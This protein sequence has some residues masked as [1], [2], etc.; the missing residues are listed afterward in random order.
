MRGTY[1]LWIAG[2]L[3]FIGLLTHQVPLLLVALLLLLVRGITILWERYS[4]KRIEFRR[5]L[6]TKRAFFGEEVVLELDI[7]NRKPLPLP[8]L[9][10]EEELPEDVTLLTGTVSQSHKVSRVYLTNLFSLGWYH[11]V[12]R[13]YR[14]RCEQR[15][16]F[17]FGPT[18]IRSGDLFG[19]SQQQMDITT[20]D[21][22][23]VYPRVLPVVQPGIPSKQPLGNIRIKRFIFPDPILTMGVREYQFG[24]SLKR[25]H[26]KTS[27]RIGRLQTKVFEPTT[28]VDMGIF[29]DVRTV[30]FPGWG[31]ITQLQEL[32]VIAAASIANQ[33]MKS[34]YRVGLYANQLRRFTGDR[35]RIAPSQHSDQ[36]MHILEALAQVHSSAE[37]TPMPRFV[38]LESRNLPWGS[39]I[40]VITAVPSEALLAALLRLKRAGRSIA[41]VKVGG[42]ATLPIRDGLPAYYIPDDVSWRDL[43]TITLHGM[44][45]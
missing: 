23:I 34:G 19:F 5:Q 24:D 11:R 20:E 43:D 25:I 21:H 10:I 3:F 15:G 2:L 26:W 29:L 6:S 33:A 27:A 30:S 39:T 41:L 45:P 40:L 16:Y 14:L 12:R 36:F 7:A 4:L 8:W 9:E 17:T 31:S 32:G 37:I 28:S 35:I 13:R 1:W 42:S 44:R 18:Q 38:T 22:L